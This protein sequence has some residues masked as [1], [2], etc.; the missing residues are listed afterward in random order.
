MNPEVKTAEERAFD[1][2]FKSVWGVQNQLQGLADAAHKLGNPGLSV[3]LNK[4]RAQLQT[5]TE[6]VHPIFLEMLEKKKQK[7]PIS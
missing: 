5:M 2:A 7:P 1:M 3:T 6:Y 4:L